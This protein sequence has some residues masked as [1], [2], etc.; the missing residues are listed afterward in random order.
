[1]HTTSLTLLQKLR[2]QDEAAWERF[3][4][5]YSPL[6]LYWARR[7]PLNGAEPAD[8][9]QDVFVKLLLELPRFT[10][11]KAKGGFR[12]WLRKV[13]HNLWSDLLRKGGNRSIQAV[14]KQLL[15]LT[16]DD[17]RFDQFWNEDYE[18]LLIH[19][20]FRVLKGEFDEISQLVF[21]EVLLNARPVQEVAKQ[22]GITQNAVSMRKFRVLRRLRKELADFL[23]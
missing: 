13:C 5:L 17:A 3:I 6:L 10:Y 11:D 7:V 1:M 4:E 16:T 2:T 9:V 21:T 22:L 23:E 19:E 14:D 20:A 15:A 12:S 8:L 18:A